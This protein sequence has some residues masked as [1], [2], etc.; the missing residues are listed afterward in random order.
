VP[1]KVKNTFTEEEINYG[2][3]KAELD[4]IRDALKRT[5]TER[6][7]MMMNLIKMGSML[8]KAKLTLK[9]YTLNK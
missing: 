3:E 5:H 9:P 1:E 7:H 4:L 6:F 2:Y 8:K